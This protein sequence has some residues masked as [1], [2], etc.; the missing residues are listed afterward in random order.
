MKQIEGAVQ[1]TIEDLPDVVIPVSEFGRDVT[2]RK[3]SD[4]V[5]A[6]FCL[7]GRPAK[8]IS[9]GGGVIAVFEFKGNALPRG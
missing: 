4:A 7:R 5:A 8:V 9:N 6:R 3:W 2:N 1:V